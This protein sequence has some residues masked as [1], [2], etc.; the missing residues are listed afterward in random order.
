M[1]SLNLV[2]NVVPILAV[3]YVWYLYA[4]G[5]WGRVAERG[6]ESKG[7]ILLGRYK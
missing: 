5:T 1:W 2:L 7:L 4:A 6:Y 3:Q